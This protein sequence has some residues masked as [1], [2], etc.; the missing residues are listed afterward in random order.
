MKKITLSLFSLAVCALTM[1]MTA[2]QADNTL[3]YNPNPVNVSSEA[4]NFGNNFQVMGGILY[5]SGDYF[6]VPGGGFGGA[7]L[8]LLENLT[9]GN[10][11]LG[12]GHAVATGFRIAEE[13]VV[14]ESVE[15]TSIDFYA[16]QTGSAPTSTITG[17]TIVIWD[18]EPGVG[19]AIY[20][21]DAISAMISTEF[22]GAYRASET[23]P[24]DNTRPIM[25]STVE[26]PGLVLTP[27]TYWIDWNSDGSLGS[28]PWA[29]PIAA[30][31]GTGSTGN[32]L[33]FNPTDG[34]W[35]PVFDNGSGNTHGFPLD[36][37]GSV[38]SLVD[39]S[40]EG[41]TY[42]PNPTT[43]ILNITAKS[44]IE[45]IAI[46]NVLGQRLIDVNPNNFNAKVNIANLSAGMYVMKATV[47]GNVG[48][49]NIIKR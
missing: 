20:G 49:F 18:G 22:S 44:N 23:T 14:T 33:Q 12:A 41:F 7:D 5:S 31:L 35:A 17:V 47:N 21:D 43:D 40:F 46:F 1:Q 2:Q 4:P 39:N 25:K 11:L 10:T 38:L 48:S 34:I 24:L 3:E 45:N 28:G 29:P 8:S 30:P 36:V 27:G 19:T 32:G 13:W 16:Y 6:N 15:V 26:T 42:Y 9:I 37:N